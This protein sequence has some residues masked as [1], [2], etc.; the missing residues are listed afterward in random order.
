MARRTRKRRAWLRRS[1]W[2]RIMRSTEQARRGRGW[3][4]EVRGFGRGLVQNRHPT[5]QAR[6]RCSPARI[7]TPGVSRSPP[8]LLGGT[9]DF[10]LRTLAGRVPVPAELARWNP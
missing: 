9:P 6:R 3:R 7:Q 5:E 4:A 10:A 1:E 8:S 2:C